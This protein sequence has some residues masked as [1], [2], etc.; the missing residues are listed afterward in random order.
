MKLA[1]WLSFPG[2]KFRSQSDFQLNP[3]FLELSVL[4]LTFFL[5]FLLYGYVQGN[6][7]LDGL[8]L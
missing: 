5:N 7:A 3:N 6:M 2:N 1:D 8:S 4:G